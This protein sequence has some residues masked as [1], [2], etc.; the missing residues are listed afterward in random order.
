MA[1]P[2]T[3]VGDCTCHL[4]GVWDTK[5][6]ITVYPRSKLVASHGLLLRYLHPTHTV[7]GKHRLNPGLH[8]K[9]KVYRAGYIDDTC[10]YLILSG[11][12]MFTDYVYWY[13]AFNSVWN[14]GYTQN[15]IR[16]YGVGVACVRILQRWFRRVLSK[17]RA[18]RVLAVMMATRI[19]SGSW[20][21]GLD[22]GLLQQLCGSI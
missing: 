14:M 9:L 12:Q 13:N 22:E 18:E 6:L 4:E 5:G 17:R 2:T 8:V 19:G 7:F 3:Y 16:V 15:M 10:I 1:C 20:L 21:H 11:E